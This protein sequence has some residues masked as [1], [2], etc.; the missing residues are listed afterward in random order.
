MAGIQVITDL[1]GDFFG[2]CQLDVWEQYILYTDY[3][4]QARYLADVNFSTF[5]IYLLGFTHKIHQDLTM[6]E[7]DLARPAS[8]WFLPG[9]V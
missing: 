5:Q 8:G 6:Y 4:N 3:K 7:T 1:D 2:K 9:S